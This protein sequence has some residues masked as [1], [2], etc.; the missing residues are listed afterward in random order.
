MPIPS[1]IAHPIP[2]SPD[3]LPKNNIFELLLV[4]LP[5]PTLVRL[6]DFLLCLPLKQR[7]ANRLA[8]F[9]ASTISLRKK[10]LV[11][12]IGEMS[13]HLISPYLL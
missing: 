13:S 4:S 9:L 6:G 7:M 10:I 5:D 2:S 8:S 11:E 3:Y 12:L 1:I